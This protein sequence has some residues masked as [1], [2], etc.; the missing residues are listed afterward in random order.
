[1]DAI[2]DLE[3]VLALCAVTSAGPHM[4]FDITLAR[5]LS[6]YTGCIFEIAV[7]DLAGSLGGGGRYDGLIGMF[8]GQNVPA[9]GLSLGLERILVV[10]ESRGMFPP[11]LERAQIVLAAVS[12]GELPHALGLSQKL[13][14]AGLAVDL[15]PNPQKP[16][17][18]RKYADDQGVACAAWFEPNQK[19]SVTLWQK[20]GDT[21]QD[22]A[23]D[24]LVTLL[25]NP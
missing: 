2:A 15:R 10:M 4:R 17:K 11:A 25:H 5:G 22:V 14:D 3:Q 21:R 18:L 9:C 6:Y 19:D 24:K 16:G 1:M 20:Q 12:E 23:L 7:A 13:R 8:S